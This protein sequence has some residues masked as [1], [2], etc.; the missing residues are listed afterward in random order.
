MA[1]L[2][3]CAYIAAASTLRTPP[4]EA[5][6]LQHCRDTLPA[7]A[8]PLRAVVLPRLPPGPAGKVLRGELPEPSWTSPLTGLL[9]HSSGIKTRVSTACL[10]IM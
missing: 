6:I 10:D 5:S 2:R 3:L 9:W 1:G 8:V 4:A 7:A